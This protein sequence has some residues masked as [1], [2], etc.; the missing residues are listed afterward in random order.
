MTNYWLSFR[1][2]ASRASTTSL[3]NI[4]FS[5]V[6]SF[7]TDADDEAYGKCSTAQ[8][9]PMGNKMMYVNSRLATR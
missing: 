1:R 2:N 8:M 4:V 3:P 7:R 9:V 6:H 5:V